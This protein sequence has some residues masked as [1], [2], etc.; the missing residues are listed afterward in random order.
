M[1][2][3]EEKKIEE[4]STEVSSSLVDDLKKFKEN[5]VPRS[6][7]EK[8]ESEYKD[9]F[10][11]VLDGR[12]AMKVEE[13]EVV[14]NDEDLNNMRE[15]LFNKEHSNLDFI[16]KSLILRKELIRRGEK[17]PFL[18]YGQNISPSFEDT[19]AAER[20][21]DVL[22]QCVDYANGDSALFTQELQRRTNDVKVRR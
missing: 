1:Q 13:G 14:L 17:D 18:P 8:L 4:Q 19:Q 20:V 11:S 9:L 2:Q 12:S 22:Q 6:D 5:T 16:E 7:F 15:D 21:A 3:S 10:N